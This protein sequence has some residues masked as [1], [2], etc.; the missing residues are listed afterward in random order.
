LLK[1]VRGGGDTLRNQSRPSILFVDDETALLRSLKEYFDFR[2]FEVDCATEMEEAQALVD[3]REYSVLVC[4]V[5]LKSVIDAAGLEVI[6]HLRGF[7]RETKII[8]L[9]AIPRPDLSDRVRE[10]H[11][12]HV[13]FKPQALHQI[14]STVDRLLQREVT[15]DANAS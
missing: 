12:D 3:C 9:T 7:S 8:I 4:D 5:A 13:L 10:L 2:G 14:E 15:T 6:S 1:H 11:V